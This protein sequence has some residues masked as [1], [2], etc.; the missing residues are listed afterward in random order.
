M[1]KDPK[2][3]IVGHS[4][5]VSYLQ[6]SL[7]T[8]NVSHAYL[9]LGPK[10]L[11][12]T[13]VAKYFVNALV[14]RE[15]GQDKAPCNSCEFCRQII[16]GVHPDV[17][18]IDRQISETSG[19]KKKN[20]SILQIRSLQNKLHLGSFLDSYKVALI[21]EA[22]TLSIEA[23]NSLLKILEEP[24]KK[25]IIILLADNNF[26]PATIVSR[27]QV[28]NFLPVSDKDIFDY[29]LTLKIDR[30][31][32]KTLTA[33][34]F[35]RPGMAA[36]FA[37]ATEEYFNFK[38]QVKQCLDIMGADLPRKFKITSEIA[39]SYDLD[40]VKE[41]LSIW[42]R[43]IRDIILIKNSAEGLISNRSFVSELT[44][45]AGEY[46]TRELIEMSNQLDLSKKYLDSNVNAKLTLEN[47]ALNF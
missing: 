16:A 44:I 22:H 34:S 14:C 28:F 27:C 32:A 10:S 31:K 7:S 5:I 15:L 19:Q 38:A 13:T 47:L 25:T 42:Q 3:P 33:L 2:W 12:K 35:G 4:N 9:F 36:H 21:T 39:S 30:K 45:L 29:L 11:G 41:T 24:A 18:W 26:L 23:A 43:I 6:N 37:S 8:L 17:F 46:S 20:I 40:L 1:L